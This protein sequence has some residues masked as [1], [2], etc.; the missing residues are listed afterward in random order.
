MAQTIIKLI[1]SHRGVC[2]QYTIKIDVLSFRK[3]LQQQQSLKKKFTESEKVDERIR[4]RIK[5]ITYRI[6]RLRFM[7]Y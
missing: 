7:I 4:L 5:W 3:L 1:L 2:F 6:V